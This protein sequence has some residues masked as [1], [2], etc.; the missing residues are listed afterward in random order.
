MDLQF[1]VVGLGA[2][3]LDVIS[4]VDHFPAGRENQQAN[5]SLLREADLSPRRSSRPPGSACARR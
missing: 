4:L 3:T 2:S 5:A 1:D